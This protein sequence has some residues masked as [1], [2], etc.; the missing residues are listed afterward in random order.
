MSYTLD[1]YT[2]DRTAILRVLQPGWTWDD[3]DQS[4]LEAY[5]M[6]RSVPHQVDLVSDYRDSPQPPGGG[7]G[8]I[9][10]FSIIWAQHPPNFGLFII[11]GA[12]EFQKSMGEIFTKTFGGSAVIARYVQTIEEAE[13]ILAQRHQSDRES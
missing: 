13:A 9:E 10:R 6:I 11:V 2:Q 8:M 7:G 1:W 12:D 4:Y 3:F 5:E